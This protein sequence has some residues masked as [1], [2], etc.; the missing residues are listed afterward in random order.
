MAKQWFWA[1][2]DSSRD[3]CQTPPVR[4]LFKPAEFGSRFSSG[5]RTQSSS[6]GRTKLNIPFFVSC[7]ISALAEFVGCWLSSGLAP[8]KLSSF[9]AALLLA[10]SSGEEFSSN[11]R[12]GLFCGG[13]FLVSSNFSV[14]ISA[15][16]LYSMISQDRIVLRGYL[17]L[18]SATMGN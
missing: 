9:V 12:F 3:L 15:P 11:W 10:A 8:T 2:R 17:L 13:E 6:E 5:S 1:E 14:A 4:E 18:G 16:F 7:W